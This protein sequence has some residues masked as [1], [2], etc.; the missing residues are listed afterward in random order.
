M[1]RSVSEV[2]RHRSSKKEADVTQLSVVHYLQV[3]WH[4]KWIV[5]LSFVLVTT[6]TYFYTRQLP[7]V[8][9]SETV[10]LVDPQKVPESYVKATV[11]GDVRNRLGTLSQQILSATR[12]QR[13]IDSVNMYASERKSLPREEV[14]SRMRR[15]ISVT[16]LSDFG[17]GGDLQAFRIGFSSTNPNL[18]AQVANELASLFIEENLKAREQQATGTT[19]FLQNQLQESRRT[20]EAQEARLKEFKLKHIG[21]LPEHQAADLQIMGQLQ[22]QL[23]LASES[24]HRAEQQK[25]YV[26]SLMA[27]QSSSTVVDLDETQPRPVVKADAAKPVARSPVQTLKARL[28]TLLTRYNDNH[29]EVKRLKAQIA[30][31]EK[32]SEAAAVA[33]AAEEPKPETVAAAS[34]AARADAPPPAPK[35]FANPVLTAQVR[36][37]ED[38]IGK[39]KAEQQR[40]I[41]M[42]QQY[43]AKLEAIPIREQEMTNLVRDYEISKTHYQQLLEKQ[44]SAET[45]TQLEIRQKGERFSVLDPAQ[46]PQKPSKPNRMVMNGAGGILGLVLGLALAL[47]TEFLGMTITSTDQ[48][49]AATGLTVLA[50]I[51]NISTY[52][53]VVAR[54]RRRIVTAA[55]V[56]LGAA[57]LAAL[58]LYQHRDQFF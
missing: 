29:P 4:R 38:E 48:I 50:S 17:G 8:Y 20:L 16:I 45:A 56:V 52:A 34:A 22:S 19:E 3:L 11:S 23:Q 57:G 1:P 32:K 13:I 6:A 43:Q 54:R 18:A 10:I 7:N 24:L 46:V 58:M 42:S 26:Q 53:D 15:D 28:D 14:I 55:S 27:S 51:P 5:L 12:L 47:V 31:E 49:T 21:E 25:N 30:A 9:T 2:P 44:L 40:L 39:Y 41:K 35:R 33:A 37:L 36:S